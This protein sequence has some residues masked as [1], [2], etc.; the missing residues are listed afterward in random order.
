MS[1]LGGRTT[2]RLNTTT[3][4]KP[5]VM[6]TYEEELRRLMRK[7]PLIDVINHTF[8]KKKLKANTLPSDRQKETFEQYIL[9]NLD[10][11]ERD[12]IPDMRTDDIEHFIFLKLEQ[13]Q[14]NTILLNGILEHILHKPPTQSMNISM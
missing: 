7:S 12:L 4:H 6:H 5:E 2:T 14:I 8:K 1:T 13:N 3:Y 9:S 10:G 11:L